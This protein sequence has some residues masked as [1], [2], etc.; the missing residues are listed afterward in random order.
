MKSIAKI[1]IPVV[2]SFGS[3]K[4]VQQS[5]IYKSNESFGKV[6]SY[7]EMARGKWS[8][9]KRTFVVTDSASF[10]IEGVPKIPI[11]YSAYIESKILPDQIKKHKYFFWKGSKREYR[12]LEK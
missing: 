2:L 7:Q 10:V 5:V 9:P 8:D 11:G 4:T 1:L 3:C 12:L 6:Q